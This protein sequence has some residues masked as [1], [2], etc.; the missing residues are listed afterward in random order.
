M[1][2]IFELGSEDS[3]RREWL[4][5]RE[6]DSGRLEPR[7]L[8][9]QLV[10]ASCGKVDEGRA[11]D[12]GVD[13]SFVTGSRLDWFRTAD[14]QVC[15]SERFKMVFEASGFEGL[16]FVPTSAPHCFVAVCTMLVDVDPALAGFKEKGH[17]GECGR[18]A[19]RYEGPFVDGLAVPA[20]AG[21]FFAAKTTNEN[22]RASYRPIFVFEST[23]KALRAANLTG[24][25]YLEAL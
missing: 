3:D 25:N 7:P 20:N 13:T 15:V 11:L 6:S 5:F 14:D 10:C 24:I 16:R 8:Y 19:E 4:F 9:R 1:A 21:A 23:V 22:A 17:C 12:L 18:P 2:V